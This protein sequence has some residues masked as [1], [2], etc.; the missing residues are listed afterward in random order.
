MTIFW[1]DT[2]TTGLGS[3]DKIVEIACIIDKDKEIKNQFHEYIKYEEYPE[4]C[5]EAFK[6]NGL[7]K[8]ILNAKSKPDITVFNNL[9]EFIK[10]SYEWEKF[11]FGGF[12]VGFDLG[13]LI[14]EIQSIHHEYFEKKN[15]DVYSMAKLKYGRNL[16]PNLKLK[17]IC[18]FEGIKIDAHSAIS[19]IMATRELYYKIQKI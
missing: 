6:I 4:E 8:E 3:H 7:S 16:L 15:I 14:K 13:F 5:E 12:V 2:E 19:D 10:S 1:I 18:E 11:I 17:T 9:I